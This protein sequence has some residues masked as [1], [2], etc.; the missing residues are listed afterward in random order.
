MIRREARLRREYIYRKSLEEKQRALDEK[1]RIVKE[2]VESNKKIPTHLQK[3]A[4]ELQKSAEWGT[5]ISVIDDEY[6]WAGTCDPKIVI[7][8]SRD[9][10]SKLKVFVKEIRLMFPTAQRINR[11]HYDV[12]KLIQACKANDIT[13]FVLLQ[14]TRGSPDGMVICHL[15]FGPTVFFTLSNVVMRHDIPDRK[16]ISEEYP[17]LI[18]NNLNSRLGVRLTTILKHLYPV[19]K[20]ES[21]RIITFSNEDDVISFR[22][23]TYF[24]NDVGEIELDEIGPRFE[25][26]PYCIKLGTFENIEAAETEW[27]LRPYINSAK[28]RPLLSLP[29]EDE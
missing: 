7:T 19:P 11:G 13:D 22:H 4:I 12:K 26:R 9:P 14:E 10:S 16:N 8:T 1:R 17:H 3:D 15:P 29:I 6:R 21:R 25:M 28:K 5:Q 20:S 23:H 24:K 27:V 2:A 18:F